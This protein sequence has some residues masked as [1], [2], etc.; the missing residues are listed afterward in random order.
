MFNIIYR[1]YFYPIPRP[2]PPYIPSPLSL[3]LIARQGI[4]KNVVFQREMFSKGQNGQFGHRHNL[5]MEGVRLS[6]RRGI[7]TI[8]AGSDTGNIVRLQPFQITADTTF[9][10]AD[11]FALR[12]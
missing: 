3:Y 7:L 10:D 12:V 6:H 4:G 8:N 9:F 11:R 2:S 5:D 1:L